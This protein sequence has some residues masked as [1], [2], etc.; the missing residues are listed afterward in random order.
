MT[1]SPMP[2]GT[3]DPG[4]GERASQQIVHRRGTFPSSGRNVVF[5]LNEGVA[6]DDQFVVRM[7]WDVARSPEDIVIHLAAFLVG[8]DSRVPVGNPY[9]SVHHDNDRSKDGSTE[10]VGRRKHGNRLTHESLTV[11]LGLVNEDVVKIVFVAYIQDAEPLSHNFDNVSGAK[12]SFTIPQPDGDSPD[13]EKVVVEPHLLDG[14]YQ[15][16]ETAAVIGELIRREDSWTYRD[17]GQPYLD[18]VEVG[19]LYGVT[20]ITG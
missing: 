11:T 4:A 3:P 20:F 12:V 17:I 16:G 7:S 6:I 1:E 15:K 14:D 10:R 8:K 5:S 19:E 18:L 13:G 2:L 9:Y